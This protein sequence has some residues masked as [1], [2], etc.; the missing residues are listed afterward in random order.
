MKKN[1]GNI[2][3]WI[4]FAI[5]IILLSLLFTDLSFKNIGWVGLIPIF[6]A[7]FK[8]CPLYSLFGIST[9]PTKED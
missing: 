4:R 3:R 8:Y 1:V 2:D 5:G 9:C 6:T 7:L